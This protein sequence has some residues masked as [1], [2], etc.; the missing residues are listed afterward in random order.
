MPQKRIPDR[1]P[2]GDTFTGTLL[3]TDGTTLLLHPNSQIPADMTPILN[4]DMMIRY[5]LPYLGKP[6]LAIVPG[7]LALDYGDMLTGDEAFNFILTKNNLYPRADVLGY[8][9][10]G[11]D[12]MI[13]IKWLDMAL[14]VQVY[15]YDDAHATKPITQIN[16]LIAP[17]NAEILPRLVA[18]LPRYVSFTQ[19]QQDQLQDNIH[20]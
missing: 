10:D 18:Y 9:N 11:V 3:Q 6:H 13:Q 15:A 12:E 17:E 5:A 7:L 2:V 20:D 8:R 16:G 1:V 19:W 4:D 14:S